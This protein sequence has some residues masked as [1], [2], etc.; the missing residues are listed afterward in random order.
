MCS[1][2]QPGA[3]L[4]SQ[5]QRVS[6]AIELGYAKKSLPV[7]GALA[8]EWVRSLSCRRY[9]VWCSFVP[10]LTQPFTHETAEDDHQ[11][12]EQHNSR[13]VVVHRRAQSGSCR[14]SGHR[15]ARPTRGGILTCFGAGL[16][17]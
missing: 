14:M 1:A 8:G 9:L 12:R 11:D 3:A 17:L 7:L 10:M 4:P 15:P 16:L 5:D 13:S 6:K 2:F